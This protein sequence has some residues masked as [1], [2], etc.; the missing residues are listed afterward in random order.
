MSLQD[1]INIALVFIAVT[2]AF[3]IKKLENRVFAKD[4][5]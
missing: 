5:L 3:R 2:Q 1:Y 4:V